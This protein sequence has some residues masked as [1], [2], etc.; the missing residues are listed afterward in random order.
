MI[1]AV[2]HAEILIAYPVMD[3]EQIGIGMGRPKKD[4]VPLSVRVPDDLHQRLMDAAVDRGVDLSEIVEEA[5]T[6]LLNK[7]RDGRA[8]IISPAR[9]APMIVR[10]FKINPALKERMRQVR[11][12]YGHGP[13]GLTC[14]ALAYFF[15]RS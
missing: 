15:R 11:R 9:T 14:A 5:L 10:S 12:T 13:Q 1:G 4:K 8:G 3:H 2:T 6:Q 7:T